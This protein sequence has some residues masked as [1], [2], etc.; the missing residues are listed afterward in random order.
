MFVVVLESLLF[1]CFE[2][3]CCLGFFLLVLCVCSSLL[4]GWFLF[5]WGCCA[6]FGVDVLFCL[7]VCL[8]SLEVFRDVFVVWGC[9]YVC[10]V[11][12]V[13]NRTKCDHQE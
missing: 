4:V 7:F 9:V 8:F 5:V 11:V 3:F 1:Y 2:N 13:L 6:L 10:V 12:V